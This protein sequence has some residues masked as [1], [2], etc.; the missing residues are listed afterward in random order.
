MLRG[1]VEIGI[2]PNSIPNGG[3]GKNK[4][5]SCHNPLPDQINNVTAERY[6]LLAFSR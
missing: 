4:T 3:V 6:K 1:K 5:L 2:V